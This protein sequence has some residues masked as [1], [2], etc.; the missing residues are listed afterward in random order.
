MAYRIL[1]YLHRLPDAEPEYVGEVEFDLRPVVGSSVSFSHKVKRETGQI[2]T[3][4]PPNW[5]SLG[6]VPAVHIAQG[7][8]PGKG[9]S[10]G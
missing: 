10:L 5:E 8:K 1:V 6:V 7:N 3:I 4:A 9:H 2:E